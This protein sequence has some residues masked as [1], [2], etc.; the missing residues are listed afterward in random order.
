MG[1]AYHPASSR[2]TR[3]DFVPAHIDADYVA[4]LAGNPNT[5]KSTVFNALTGLKQHTGNWPGKT[6]SQARGYYRHQG[7][8]IVLVDLPGT[9]SL[10]A[11]SPEEEV[12]RDFIC[13]AQP[14][15]TVVIVDTTCLERNLNLVLQVLEI[16]PKV[17]VCLNLIDE[18]ERK[19]LNIDVGQLSH[20]LGVPVVPTAARSGR[21][22]T[23]LKDWISAIASGESS[24]Q[25]RPVQYC[26]PLERAVERLERYLQ[27]VYTNGLSKRWVALR[28]L[29]GDSAA[30]A[31][32]RHY[33]LAGGK[34]GG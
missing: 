25:P 13:F 2:V 34:Q 18:A 14:D 7:R 27:H 17:I 26:E 4:A 30:I 8:N 3:E 5:G 15:V 29:E 21:G 28:L 32:I 12:A 19:G 33:S 22:M 24:T 20:K 23:L 10:L 6:V 1:T 9:Y 11:S 31:A 16:T